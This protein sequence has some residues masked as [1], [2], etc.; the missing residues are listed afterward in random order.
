MATPLVRFDDL[1]RALGR[2]GYG[3]AG[4]TGSHV[5]LRCPGRQPVTVPRSREIPRG[6][7][8][9]ILRTVDISE[10]ELGRLLK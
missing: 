5:R 1:I 10:D 2:L 9:A 3:I 4:Q 7:L 6:T 8:R